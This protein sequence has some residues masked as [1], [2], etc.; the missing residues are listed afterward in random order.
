MPPS[1]RNNAHAPALSMAGFDFDMGECDEDVAAFVAARTGQ[2]QPQPQKNMKEED[3]VLRAP[4][5]P[6]APSATQQQ[7]QKQKQQQQQQQQHNNNN[8]MSHTTTTAARPSTLT[9]THTHSHTRTHTRCMRTFDLDVSRGW[10]LK[11]L[12]SARI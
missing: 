11:H 8:S 12:R 9:H 4:N 5:A 10:G 6:A 3:A 7:K 1:S 2:T